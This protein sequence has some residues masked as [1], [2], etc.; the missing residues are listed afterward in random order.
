MLEFTSVREK[1][2]D[3]PNAQRRIAT[4]GRYP[5]LYTAFSYVMTLVCM[6]VFVPLCACFCACGLSVWPP[7]ACFWACARVG[8]GA[9]VGCGWVLVWVWWKDSHQMCVYYYKET[10]ANAKRVTSVVFLNF[11]ILSRPENIDFWISLRV[12]SS[13]RWCL[14]L[15]TQVKGITG[16]CVS[17]NMQWSYNE[18]CLQTRM[19]DDPKGTIDNATKIVLKNARYPSLFSLNF[20]IQQYKCIGI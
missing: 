15:I 13:C 16:A 12:V 10:N 2:I 20:N 11:F 17:H 8:V 18:T 7:C 1:E 9:G 5:P 6:C 3:N 14:R 19:G 4:R